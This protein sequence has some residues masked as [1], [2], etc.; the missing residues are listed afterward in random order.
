VN[1]I[2][3]GSHTGGYDSFNFDISQLLKEDTTDQE[4]LVIVEDPTESEVIPVGKQWSGGERP[5]KFIFYTPTSG[6]WQ[7]VW[8]EGVPNEHVTK[9]SVQLR[10]ER[11][12]VEVTVKQRGSAD[13]SVS[14]FE[15]ENGPCVGEGASGAGVV[16][17]IPLRNPKLWTPDNPFLYKLQVQLSSG[18]IVSSYAGLRTIE[19]TKKEDHQIIILNGKPLD[20]QV[21]PLDQGYWPDGLLTPPSE[22][23]IRWD[24][25]RMKEMGFNMVR[26]HIK[27]EVDRWYYWADRLGLLVWQDFPCISDRQTEKLHEDWRAQE[28][29]M[30]ASSQWMSQLDCHPSIIIWVVF[31]EAWG[32]F[33][34]KEVASEVMRRDP[35]RLVVPTSGWNDF[36]VGHIKDIHVYPGPVDDQGTV[37]KSSTRAVV[38]GEMWGK[39]LV[40]WG[41]CWHGDAAAREKFSQHHVGG[42]ASKEEFLQKY[43]EAI[44]KLQALKAEGYMAAV[45]TQLSDVEAELNGFFSYDRQIVKVDLNALAEMHADLIS[46]Q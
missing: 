1:G 36:E 28:H 9:I 14:L 30:I 38:L 26:K 20:F 22:E 43:H 27:I 19:L 34:T 33:L 6:I 15:E 3:A 24:L 31:N 7:T 42:L 2:Q 17:A 12:L 41:H 4:L 21:G 10:L 39:S 35:S 16:V 5:F 45:F 13:V 37:V 25:E 46:S 8:L 40:P 29:F 23:A 44:V 18:D 32:Q 11:E